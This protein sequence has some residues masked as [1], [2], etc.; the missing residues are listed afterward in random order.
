MLQFTKTDSAN[1]RT[2][3]GRVQMLMAQTAAVQ[4]HHIRRPAMMRRPET[5]NSNQATALVLFTSLVEVLD[6]FHTAV[7]HNLGQAHSSRPFLRC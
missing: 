2:R 7:F 6:T 5:G 4:A 3:G 1:G